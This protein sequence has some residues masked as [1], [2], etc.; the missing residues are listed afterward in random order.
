MYFK[1]VY[2]S[3]LAAMKITD[4]AIR[5]KDREICGYLTGFPRN[6]A[7]YVLDAVE[8]PII[9]SDS[10]VQVAGE[11]GDKAQVYNTNLSELLSK[12]GR[13]HLL[14]GWYHSHPGFG[15]FLSGIDCNTQ[16]YMQNIYQTFFALVVDP[17]RS[18]SS[19]KLQIGAFF[20][21]QKEQTGKSNFFESV[22]LF[23]SEVN[24]FIKNFI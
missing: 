7:F 2:I 11:M 9:G 5:G 17:Y 4:H 13:E 6:G 10:R 20:C 15:C 12:V 8:L 1:K 21:F 24:I 14:V 3:T 23:M 22:P 16:K 18:L 19:R